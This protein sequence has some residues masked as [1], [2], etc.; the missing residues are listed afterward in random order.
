MVRVLHLSNAAL[1]FQAERSAACL[2]S[3]AGDSLLIDSRRIG[4]GGDYANSALA[5]LSLLHEDYGLIHAWSESALRAAA[6]GS[7]A[8]VVYSP[9]DFPTEGMRRWLGAI[10]SWRELGVVCTAPRRRRAYLKLGVAARQC[11]LIRPGIDLKTCGE[12]PDRCLRPSLGFT[13]QD[14]VL[15]GA[16]ESSRKPTTALHCGRRQSCTCLTRDLKFSSGDAAFRL[17]RPPGSPGD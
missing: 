6:I 8:P 16:G 13:D 3:S 10:A 14:V 7:R 5:A 9:T 2:R 1:D 4:K 12:R 17:D 11:H 15:L